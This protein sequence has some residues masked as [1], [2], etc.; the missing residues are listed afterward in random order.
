MLSAITEESPSHLGLLDRIELQAN[1][2]LIA[3]NALPPFKRSLLRLAG[4]FAFSTLICNFD[5]ISN[6]LAGG[7]IPNSGDFL[8]N[9]QEP[10]PEPTF[11][12]TPC[13]VVKDGITSPG[14]DIQPGE[15]LMDLCRKFVE[16]SLGIDPS[17]DGFDSQVVLLKNEIQDLNPNIGLSVKDPCNWRVIGSPGCSETCIEVPE[18]L[19][20]HQNGVDINSFMAP[21]PNEGGSSGLT[22]SG[23]ET[24]SRINFPDWICPSA[25][26][27]ILVAGVIALVVPRKEK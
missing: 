1:K 5:N 11:G 10:T 15:T 12:I 4:A 7:A 22:T 6:V 21:I 19:R 9:V 13:E 17:A 18:A 8:Q 20:I 14:W 24:S 27:V 25:M 2:A 26:A 16:G 23:T 3:Y